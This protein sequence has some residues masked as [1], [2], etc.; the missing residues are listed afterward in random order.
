[1]IGAAGTA[2][3]AG[4]R[5]GVSMGGEK[6]ILIVDDDPDVHHL[7]RVALRETGRYMESAYDGLE[8]LKKF[9][10]GQWDLLITDVIMPGIDGMELLERISKIRPETPVVV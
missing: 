4:G 3:G 10:D 6:R 2:V 1:S 8:A 5:R 9:E 7:L